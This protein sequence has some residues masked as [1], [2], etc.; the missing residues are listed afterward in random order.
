MKSVSAFRSRP[1]AGEEQPAA[2]RISKGMGLFSLALGATQLAVPRALSRLIGI[3]PGFGVSTTMRLAGVREIVSGIAVLLEPRRPTPMYMRIAGDIMDF[4]LLALGARHRTSTPRFLGGVAAVAGATA[5][6]VI[7]ALGLQRAHAAANRPVLYSVTINKPP[8]EVYAFYRRFSQLPLFM[9]YLESVTE[10]D[11]RRSRWVARLPLG[12][13]LAWEAEI[14]DDVPGQ[15]I[16][17]RST[18]DSRIKTRGRVTF[19]QAPGRSASSGSGLAT[20][21][22]VEMALGFSGKE[23]SAT[24]AKFFAKPQIKGDL[25]RLKQVLETGEVLYSDASEFARPHPAQPAA[26][27]QRRPAIF[28]PNP[29]TAEKGISR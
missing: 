5:L 23:P 18:E 9:N 2:T 4:G 25:R 3:R 22:R 6:D 27:V 10:Y 11:A 21:V 26:E 14:T 29:P 28:I 17:W 7:G 24:L 20:E 16:A 1:D 19:M 12:K 15:I 8:A 13:S